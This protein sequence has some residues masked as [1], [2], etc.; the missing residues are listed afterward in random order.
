MDSIQLYLG[1]AILN[2][3]DC[4]L[5]NDVPFTFMIPFKKVIN[6]ILNYKI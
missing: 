3:P 6:F 1:E 4:L 5:E 2:L